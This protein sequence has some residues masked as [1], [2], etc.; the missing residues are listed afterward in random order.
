MEDVM[1]LGIGC[2]INLRGRNKT[3]CVIF[4]GKNPCGK[5]TRSGFGV[6]W[7]CIW[8]CVTGKMDIMG[9]IRICEVYVYC[10]PGAKKRCLLEG[11][12]IVESARLFLRLARE[13][14]GTL[15]GG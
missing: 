6:F 14:G 11:D 5:L 8:S 13:S 10:R 2:V 9:K 7:K 12:G 1:F 3:R 15:P 4:G